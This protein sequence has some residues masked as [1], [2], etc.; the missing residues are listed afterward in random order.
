MKLID[1]H[2]VWF[3]EPGRVK[4]GIV[5][6]CPCCLGKPMKERARLA[7]AFA[8]PLDGGPVFP[9]HNQ[10]I[11]WDALVWNVGDTAHPVIVPPGVHWERRGN[12]F[13]IMTLR[14][15]IDASD[16]RHWHGFVSKGE[17]DP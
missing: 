5:F 15:S 1:L 17:I 10:G 14:P 8:N 7:V 6:D 3:A 9:I 12:A 13:E 16:A 4:Q 11:L 2:P